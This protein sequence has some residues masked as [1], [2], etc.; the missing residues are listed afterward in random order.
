MDHPAGVEHDVIIVWKNFTDSDHPDVSGKSDIHHVVVSDWGRDIDAYFKV[1]RMFDHDA[2][3][4]LN[5]WS[6]INSDDWLKTM[7]DAMRDGVGLV[8]AFSSLESHRRNIINKLRKVWGQSPIWEKVFLSIHAGYRWLRVGIHVSPYPNFHVRTNGF[9]IRRE[10]MMQIHKPVIFDKL[11]AWKFESGYN[12]MTRRVLDKGY[13]VVCLDEQKLFMDNR[14]GSE[15][16]QEAG[17]PG[18]QRAQRRH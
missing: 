15:R 2:F 11:G 14:V 18:L 5:S 9:M 3:V 10:V 12:G 7:C 4:F 6:E 16:A 1:S 13:E 8:G 17:T